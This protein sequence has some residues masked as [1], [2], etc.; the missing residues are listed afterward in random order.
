[1]NLPKALR[2]HMAVQPKRS[3]LIWG[4][5][6]P[7]EEITVPNLINQERLPASPLETNNWQDGTGE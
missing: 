3:L 5:A 7:R 6:D 1:V 2:S 4:W